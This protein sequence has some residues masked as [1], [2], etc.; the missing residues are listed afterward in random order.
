MPFETARRAI[1]EVHRT[2][3]PDCVLGFYIRGEPTLHPRLAEMVAH[4]REKGMHKLLLSTNLTRLDRRGARELL[5]AG[6]SELRLSID[7]ADKDTFEKARRGADFDQVCEAVDALFEERRRL[8]SHCRFRLH[9]ALDDAGFQSVPSFVRRWNSAV[10]CFKFTVAVNQGGLLSAR[11]ARE[12]S[13]LDF[14]RAERFQIPCRLLFNSAGITWDGKITSCCVD[15]DERFV[16][17]HI[18]EGIEEVFLN[19]RSEKLRADHAA[20]NPGPVCGKCG[21]AN[22]LVDWF[23]DEVNEFVDSHRR[24]LLNP[25]FDESYRRWLRRSL[26]KFNCLASQHAR[27]G[28]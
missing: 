22:A 20:G 16:V 26:A 7:G 2:V 17:G 21:F 8:S 10:D 23:E 6:L 24:R 3:G 14:A 1:D 12:I 28:R 13:R 18:E 19:A 25:D 11:H 9:A 27:G 5:A 15:Y 4:A